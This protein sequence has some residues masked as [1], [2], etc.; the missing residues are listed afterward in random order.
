MNHRM[1]RL[2]LMSCMN[3]QLKMTQDQITD[4]SITLILLLISTLYEISTAKI[5]MQIISKSKYQN[6]FNNQHKN[7]K[8]LPNVRLSEKRVLMDNF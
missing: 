4:T 6:F 5:S 8:L 2:I 3:L 1:V 7:D